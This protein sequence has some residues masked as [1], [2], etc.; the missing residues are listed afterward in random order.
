MDGQLLLEST[1]LLIIQVITYYL[2][3]VLLA[4]IGQP[5]WPRLYGSAIPWQ[6]SFFNS[7]F[8]LFPS[9]AL[10]S[11]SWYQASETPTPLIS[12]LS[13]YWLLASLFTNHNEMESRSRGYIHTS[14]LGSTLSITIDSKRKNFNTLTLSSSLDLSQIICCS[15]PLFKFNFMHWI[16]SSLG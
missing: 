7:T 16:V 1:S 15:V 9:P 10:Y 6:L 14:S 3:G 13:R 8:F 12:L 4:P 2:S 5:T 11:S